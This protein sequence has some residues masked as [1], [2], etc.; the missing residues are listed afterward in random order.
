MCI[1]KLHVTL[2]KYGVHLFAAI[3]SIVLLS[4]IKMYLIQ[5]RLSSILLDD[6]F[7]KTNLTNI[8]A[9]YVLAFFSN[10][11]QSF[12]PNANPPQRFIML[13]F[14]FQTHSFVYILQKIKALISRLRL[15]Q[16]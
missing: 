1:H 14:F 3:V 4:Y 7:R 5:K 12:D 11:Y 9:G 16:I 10:P 13:S 15:M 2:H 8:S 6:V